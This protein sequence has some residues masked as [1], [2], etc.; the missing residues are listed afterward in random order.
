MVAKSH[1]VFQLGSHST[2]VDVGFLWTHLWVAAP[3]AGGEK[4]QE[5]LIDVY[6][7]RYVGFIWTHFR[8]ATLRAGG[9]K[10]KNQLLTLM[11]I[12]QSISMASIRGAVIHYQSDEKTKSCT[13]S[14]NQTC[15]S[16]VCEIN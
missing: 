3:C 6:T 8:V 16:K 4:D 9:E 15:F 13:E 2:L 11:S 14:G 7:S 5:E 12:Y 10:I 1:C